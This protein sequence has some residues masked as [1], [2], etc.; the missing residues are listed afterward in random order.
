MSCRTASAALV[1]VLLATPGVPARADEP[2]WEFGLGLAAVRLPHYRGSDQSHDWV[3]PLPYA[4]YRGRVFRADRD[5]A[6]AVLLDTENL[7][8]DLSLAATAPT[9]SRDDPARR[10]MPDLA[11]TL[12][13]GPNLNLTLARGADWKAELRVPVRAVF[14]VQSSPRAI[15]ATVSP[16]LNLDL[17]A[18]GWDLGV[19]GGPLAATKAYHAYF[20]DVA[21]AYA[22]DERPAYS[23]DG[24]AA[25]WRLGTSASRR[26]GSWWLGGFVRADSLA[27]AVFEAS[28]LV[29]QRHNL[30]F[31]VAASWIFMAS[32]EHVADRR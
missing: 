29:R 23:A 13:F 18:A 6:R 8:F 28:P 9:K 25:G 15:G 10:G 16:A 21:P 30:S 27:G 26:L 14:T 20:Y 3:L 17:V 32:S 22:N 1:M 12:E 11:P 5:G 24:G 4:V 31:G 19:Q 2:L 7:D